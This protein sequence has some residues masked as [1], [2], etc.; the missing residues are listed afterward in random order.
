MFQWVAAAN[1]LF[2]VIGLIFLVL[3]TA[4]LARYSTFL[5]TLDDPDRAGAYVFFIVVGLPMLIAGLFL[6]ADF[7]FGV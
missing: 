5:Y 2:L 1:V 3:L 6:I 4:A 7:I